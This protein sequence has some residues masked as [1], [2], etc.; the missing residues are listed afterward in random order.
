[1]SSGAPIVRQI[2]WLSVVP[3][4]AIMG[5]IMWLLSMAGVQEAIFFGALAYLALSMSLRYGVAREHRRG[6]SL[7]KRKQYADAIPSFERSYDFF[8]R[9]RWLDD[10][11]FLTLLSSSRISYREMALLNMAFCHA[12]AGNGLKAKEFYR[13]TQAEFPESE[14]AKASLRM[15]ESAEN[16]ARPSS[17]GDAA[18]RAGPEK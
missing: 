8:S 13:R 2:A 14:M 10:W 11:R 7:F 3:Q 4:L 18:H 12:Q 6:I 15:I 9:Y 5:L 1:M 17:A 16:D